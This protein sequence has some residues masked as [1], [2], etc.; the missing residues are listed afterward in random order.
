[1]SKKD[2]AK[3]E[4]YLPEDSRKHLE[5][6]FEG[7]REPVAL[8]VFTKAGENDPYN[9]AMTMFMRDVARLGSKIDV[10]FHDV[11]SEKAQ[12]RDVTRSPTLL[13]AP[14]KYAIRYTG[15]PLGEEART[16][17]EILM[18]ASHEQSGL[19]NL[20][21]QI[22]GELKEQRQVRVFISPT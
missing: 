16:F 3:D 12:K 4:W 1:M 11:V 5:Q 20:S 19:S 8:E 13:V 22:L 2:S 21:Q 15:A 10:S 6:L 7:L 17:I 18:L 14:D 9:E